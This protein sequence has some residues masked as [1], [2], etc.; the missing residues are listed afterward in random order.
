MSPACCSSNARGC[1]TVRAELDKKKIAARL[2]DMKDEIKTCKA[3]IKSLEDDL[4]DAR[5]HSKGSDANCPACQLAKAMQGRQPSTG[6]MILQGLQ[7]VALPLVGTG[8]NTWMN[9]RGQNST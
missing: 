4:K 8:L 9:V 1:G 7:G 6:E 5:K 3:D 2:D